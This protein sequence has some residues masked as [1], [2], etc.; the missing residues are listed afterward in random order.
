MQRVITLLSIIFLVF[1]SQAQLERKY[2]TNDNSPKWIQLLYTDGADPA[3]VI[4]AHDR[5]FAEHEKIKNEHTQYYKRWLRSFSRRES[6]NPDLPA[7]QAY[8]QRS[9]QLRQNKAPNSQWNCIGPYD[10]DHHAASTSYAPGAAHVYTVEQ[11]VSNPSIMFAGTATAG[12]WKSVDGGTLWSL[13]TRD[14]T[15]NGIFAIEIDNTNPD[16]VYFGSGGDLYK[17]TN[18]GLTWNVIGDAA[19][20]TD[21]HDFQD[22]VMSPSNPNILYL[23]SNF[24]FYRTTD[25]GANWSQIMSGDFQEIELNPANESMIYTIK[26][27]NSSTEFYKSVN[28]GLSFTV[29]TNGWPSPG[30]NAEQRRVEIAVTPADPTRI[31]ANATGSANGGSGTYGIYLSTDEGASWTFQCCGTQPAGPPSASNQNLMGWDKNGLDDGGQYYYDVALAADPVNPDILHLGGVNHWISTDAG[32]SWTCPSA[33]SESGLPSYVHADIHDIRFFG[34]DLW[35]ACDGGVFMSSD[36][37]VNV[38]RSMEGIEGSDFWGFGAS[39]QSDVMLGGAYHNGTLMKDNGTYINDWICT[40]GGDGVRGFVNFGNDRVA[41]HDWGGMKMSGD[42]TV[43]LGSFSFDSLPNSSYI[44]GESSDMCWDPRNYNSIYIGRGKNLLKTNDNGVTYTVVHTFA[45]KVTS[46]EI[47]WSNLDVIYVCTYEDWWGAKKI[48]RTVDGGANWIEI[49]PPNALLVNQL[50]VPYDITV[51][52][53][54]ENLIW[55]ARTSQYG[56]YPDLD[57]RKVYMSTN[58]GANWTNITTSTLDGEWPTNIVHQSGTDG[59]VYIGTRRAVYYRNNSMSDWALFNND[60]PLTTFSTRLVPMYKNKKLLNATNRSVYEVDFYEPSQ[61][62]A[63]IAADRFTVNCADET[64]QFVDHSILSS[65]N[66]TWQWSFP[67][68]SPSASTQQNPLVTYSSPGFYDVSLTVTDAF[69]TSTQ[70]YTAFIEYTNTVVQPDLQEDFEAGITALWSQRNLNGSYGWSE[71]N[72]DNGPYCVPT[73]CVMLDHYNI[74]A[75]G[76]EAELITPAIDLSGSGLTGVSLHFDYA[77]A[78]Y[79]GSYEDGFHIDISTD[80]WN[81]CDTLW[82][83]FGDSLATV[84]DQGNWWEPQDCADWSVDNIIDLSSYLGQEIRLRFVG[85]NGWG[86]NFYLDNINVLGQLSGLQSQDDLKVSLYPN[87]TRNVLIVEQNLGTPTLHI[88]TMDGKAVES[89]TLYYAKEV[90]HL[91]ITPGVYVVQ[92]QNGRFSHVERLVVQ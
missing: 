7:D 40:G 65:D 11:S 36:G 47:A 12:L 77:Y 9:M 63:Q 46:V 15:I 83:A 73:E 35:I 89:R 21:S 20:Q 32:V 43:N 71:F 22:I 60:L 61:P 59:G 91:D 78:K 24:G 52:T 44:V 49:T 68:G 53:S 69:G 3:E 76:D 25:G 84:P 5:Y 67:G 29:Q 79:G 31:Y 30:A 1:S 72:S 86:N 75:P 26:V 48:W 37:G 88:T 55:I 23:T 33:W 64:V 34:T 2:P 57:G 13:M 4:R 85:I 87:P 10:F 45:D 56:D 19:F 16:I 92:I 39:P 82:Y 17:T 14:L 81:T 18:G 74:N 41:Y 51:S 38:T 66:A 28:G 8:L 27:V 54:D 62:I 80:C 42:R 90:V 70:S 6:F 50:W 58:G